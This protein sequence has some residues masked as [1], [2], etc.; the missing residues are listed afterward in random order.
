M[1]TGCIV[2]YFIAET[3]EINLFLASIFQ[4]QLTSDQRRTVLEM[5]DAL[6]ETIITDLYRLPQ[7]AANPTCHQKRPER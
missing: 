2:P 6:K 4:R 5:L 1:T 3:S 7:R